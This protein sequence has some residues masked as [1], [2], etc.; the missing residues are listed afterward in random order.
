MKA[1]HLL[2]L[3]LRSMDDV[4]P[5]PTRARHLSLILKHTLDCAAPLLFSVA[6]YTHAHVFPWT[7]MSRPQSTPSEISADF[8]LISFHMTG[9]TGLPVKSDVTVAYC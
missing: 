3:E 6:R 5:A 8:L 1:F 9:E 2:L 7:E 4:E